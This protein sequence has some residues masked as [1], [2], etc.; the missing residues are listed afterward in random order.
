MLYSLSLISSLLFIH[1]FGFLPTYSHSS[2]SPSSAQLKLKKQ[3]QSCNKCFTH[4]NLFETIKTE[5]KWT[6]KLAEEIFSFSFLT[7]ILF[8]TATVFTALRGSY[9]SLFYFLV[10]SFLFHRIT[11]EVLIFLW[12]W[13]GNQSSKGKII[14]Q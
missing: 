1:S 11:W 9:P 10:C 4:L 14:C 5:W 3:P 12:I 7:L 8:F 13:I 6:W 2:N